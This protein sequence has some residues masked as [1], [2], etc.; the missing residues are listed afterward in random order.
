MPTVENW[1][2]RNPPIPAIGME[3]A[4][5]GSRAALVLRVSP[6]IPVG[7]KRDDGQRE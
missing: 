2:M 5:D 7:G 4:E 6:P 1:G 3:V